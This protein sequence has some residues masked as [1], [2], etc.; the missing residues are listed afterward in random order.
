[1]E[2]S[3]IS[4]AKPEEADVEQPGMLGPQPE[5]QDYPMQ[6]GVK[7][8]GQTSASPMTDQQVAD[9]RQQAMAGVYDK[10]G[11]ADAANR[12]RSSITQNKMA[13]L[14]LSQ[15]ERQGKRED[16]EDQYTEGRKNLF[17]N[18]IYNQKQTGFASAQSDYESA[19]KEYQGKVSAGQTDA[20]A[21]VAPAKPSYGTAE[22]LL[23]HASLLAYDIQN[24]KAGSDALVNLTEMKK[25]V[26][27]EG[28][29]RALKIAQSGAPLE[30]VAKSFNDGGK[31]KLDPTS[32]VS[33]KIK[34]LGNGL[35]TRLLTVK[36]P[37]GS[38]HTIDTMAELDAM[39]KADSLFSRMFQAEGLKNQKEHIKIAQGSLGIQGQQLQ[40]AKD[41]RA[42]EILKED[43]AKKAGVSLYQEAHPDATAPQLEA[44]RTGV[45]PAIVGKGAYKVESGDVTTLLGTPAVDE[46]GK[47]MMDP[48][49]GKQLVN[50]DP[51]KEKQFFEW[52]KKQG[53]TDTN[54]GLAQYLGQQKPAASEPIKI[55]TPDDYA[56]L[57][58]GA[59]YIAPDGTVRTK[60]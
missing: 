59:S 3:K 22:S 32:V 28:Y 1:M 33:D 38:T 43:D 19:M 31:V 24:N 15:A 4:T 11:D 21:P 57:P 35:K 58:K 46:R 23:D 27:D 51:E 14:Q 60:K 20:I 30:E 9:A 5:G 29:G 50:R 7:F 55:S 12:I 45:M 47:P 16:R 44:V 13:N 56:K 26:D 10:Y 41:Q 8:L 42:R 53:I 18:S 34:D 40:L 2:L 52:M 17:E 36:D 25:Q 54:A 6:K 39:G 37:D 48:I 49:S